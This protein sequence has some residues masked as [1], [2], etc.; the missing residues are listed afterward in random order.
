MQGLRAVA[1]ILVVLYHADRVLSGGYIGVDVF[2]VISGFVIMAMMLRELDGTGSLDLKRFYTRRVRR[3]LPALTLMLTVTAIGSALILSP[4]G[5]QQTAADTGQAAS[6]FAANARLY[7]SPTAYFAP[8]A[9]LNPLLHTW[10]LA[11]EEQFYL[12]FPVALFVAWRIGRRSPRSAALIV[13]VAAGLVSF[14]ASVLLVDAP[15]QQS[16]LSKPRQFSFYSSPTRAWEFVAGALLA[17]IPNTIRRLPAVAGHVASVVGMAIIIWCSFAYTDFTPFPGLAAVPPVIGTVLLVVGGGATTGGLTAALSSRVPVRLGDLSYSW[18]LW[19]WPAIVFTAVLFPNVNLSIIAGFGSIVLAWV[20]YV[21]VEEWFRH[22]ERLVGVRSIALVVACVA[23]PV[24][25]MAAVRAGAEQR[26]GDETLDEVAPY[27]AL[28]ED[29]VR[30]CDATQGFGWERDRCTWSP[31]E[32]AE[33]AAATPAA[34]T[35]LL[36]GDSHAGHLTEAVTGAGNRL[37]HDVIVRTFSACPFVETSLSYVDGAPSDGCRNYVSAALDQ[38][39]ESEPDLVVISTAIR[40]YLTSESVILGDDDDFLDRP[41]EERLALWQQSFDATLARF[42]EAGV[43]VLVVQPLPVFEE[44][45]LLACS[46]LTISTDPASCGT[47]ADRT[48]L[49]AD[50]QDFAAANQASADRFDAVSTIDLFDALC[51]DSTC[52]TNDGD[53]F[54]YRDGDHLTVERATLLAEDFTPAIQAAL[55]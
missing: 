46:M 3:L 7:L 41:I 53:T 11:V 39:I 50:R 28:H 26:W 19:H 45:S 25:A 21:L 17:F 4:F 43:P 29:V 13:L 16:V 23:I 42:D 33:A 55:G 27:T 12:L 31:P 9:E 24:V 22:N 34:G 6:L 37:G 35:V 18:Y 15:D 44:W 1:V 10:S 40:E 32:D 5:A 38:A 2:F 49:L 51:P 30:G 20:S 52:V 48:E 8:A 54:F 14:A 36:F 47:E